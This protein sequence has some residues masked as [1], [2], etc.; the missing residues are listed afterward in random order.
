M[1][2]LDIQSYKH[3]QRLLLQLAY[4]FQ[5]EEVKMPN[6]K[7][8]SCNDKIISQAVYVLHKRGLPQLFSYE[9]LKIFHHK[10]LTMIQSDHKITFFFFL[11]ESNLTIRGLQET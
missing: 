7:P 8:F 3:K 1:E 11:K 5:E 4:E 10:I 2:S 6:L 9:P